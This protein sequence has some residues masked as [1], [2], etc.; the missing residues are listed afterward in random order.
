MRKNTDLNF[1]CGNKKEPEIFSFE[2]SFNFPR[3][4]HFTLKLTT[5]LKSL[6]RLILSINVSNTLFLIK[7]YFHWLQIKANVGN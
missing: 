7:S 3:M 5:F 6:F 1:I 2:Y 4:S